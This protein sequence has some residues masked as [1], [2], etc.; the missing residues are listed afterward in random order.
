MDMFGHE[1]REVREKVVIQ[2]DV[3]RSY[4]TKILAEGRKEN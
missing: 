4:E 3:S 2:K 1:T